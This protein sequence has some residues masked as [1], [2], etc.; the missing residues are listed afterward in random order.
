MK[1]FSKVAV[2]SICFVNFLISIQRVSAGEDY[3]SHELLIRF[4]Q[5]LSLPAQSLKL[6][7]ISGLSIGVQNLLQSVK[8]TEIKPLSI[9]KPKFLRR[10]VSFSAQNEMEQS[11]EA[12]GRTYVL[13]FDDSVSIEGAMA[14]LKSDPSVEICEPNFRIKYLAV[15]NDP[16][17]GNLWALANT[18]QPGVAGQE[19]DLPAGDPGIAGRDIDAQLAWDLQKGNK[20]IVVAVIDSGVDWSHPDLTSN[21]WA[22]TGEIP[23]NGFD[24]DGNG[25]VDDVRGWDF[26]NGD[27]N[28]MDDCSNLN[29]NL[30]AGG[31]GT[32][33]AGIIGAEGNNSVGVT[34]V[35]WNVSLM[36]VKAA[37]NSC[38]MLTSEVV[39]SIVYAVQN[40]ADI[41]NMSL[42]GE[43]SVALKSAVDAAYSGGVLM[44][45]AAG[46]DNSTS[47][48]NSYP[49][50]YSNV[51]SVAATNRDDLK[52]SFSNYGNWVTLSAPGVAIYSTLPGGTY[53]YKSGT[54][55]ASPM[56]A[57]VAALILAQSPSLTPAE[58]KN[59]LVYSCENID[60]LNAGYAG[61][62]GAGRINAA[63]GLVSVVSV[64]P[65]FAP[66][67][68][69]AAVTVTG[70]ALLQG[71]DLQLLKT[72]Q[73]TIAAS[74]VV[75]HSATSITG[76]FDLTGAAGGRWDLKL[77][78]GSVNVTAA[79]GF[80]VTSEFYGVISAQPGQSS[81]L[82][83]TAP[84]GLQTFFLPAVAVAQATILDFNP[85]PSH[86]ALN[87]F[88]DPYQPTNI[89]TEII[90]D[91]SPL[92]LSAPLTLTLT[93]RLQDLPDPSKE[94]SLT[95]AVYNSV[96]GRWE[97]ISSVVDKAA[98]TVSASV[99]HLS[100]FQI[101]QHTASADLKKV[102]AFPNPFRTDR[103]HT[104]IVF[105]FLTAGSRVRIY[106]VAGA[107]IADLKDD[108]NDGQIIWPVT[109]GQNE[110]IASGIYFYLVTD[111]SG[112]KQTGRLGVV[113]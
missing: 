107:L 58:L 99:R 76:K 111:P 84:Q 28:P 18:G 3:A 20:N 34:G 105:D 41:I 65:S 1:I 112:N 54:S 42:G 69:T 32:H 94:D 10:Q 81:N 102:V 62:L 92:S 95:I 101:L 33:V 60:G 40:G 15:P 91:S 110:K 12:L 13:R 31:H 77:T 19:G 88:L 4:R 86:P 22:N 89:G 53:G 38:Y 83:L 59:R 71:M 43:A 52:A 35:N 108:N 25:F 113:R 98:R 6:Q 73:P 61:L 103:G 106:D 109:N 8:A 27:N 2:F 7:G 66:T 85:N 72:G 82:S 5:G 93:Y 17:Y 50:A 55:M 24:D 45:A 14:R 63:G 23:G 39:N 78:S 30:N 70:K 68:S 104:R 16:D 74:N 36:P 96:T 56:V 44:I 26:G 90:P 48:T 49:A 47:Q 97:P 100:I 9:S 57:G 11:L 37:D 79:K 29:P 46:N 80:A 64:S 67:N 51:I 87:S 21:V 75:F